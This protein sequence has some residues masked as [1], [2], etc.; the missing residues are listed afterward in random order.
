[1][2]SLAFLKEIFIQEKGTNPSSISL[3]EFWKERFSKI[4][5]EKSCLKG[6]ISKDKLMFL[7]S[8]DQPNQDSK[9]SK[10][11]L[12]YLKVLAHLTEIQVW[13]YFTL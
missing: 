7:L 1:M 8:P 10:S 13:T 2:E 5:H 9:T 12:A 3:T 11:M 6:I 4:A